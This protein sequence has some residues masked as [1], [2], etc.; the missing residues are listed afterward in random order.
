[1]IDDIITIRTAEIKQT[2]VAIFR[3]TNI[4]RQPTHY[5]AYFQ[6]NYQ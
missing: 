2:G 1:M 3:L 4:A 6:K 5:R